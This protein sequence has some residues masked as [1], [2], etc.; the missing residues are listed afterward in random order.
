MLLGVIHEKL[1]VQLRFPLKQAICK[2]EG[3]RGQGH[4][5][6]VRGSKSNGAA[7]LLHASQCG[8]AAHRY[9]RKLLLA[10]LQAAIQGFTAAKCFIWH[11]L[12]QAPSQVF[13]LAL[14]P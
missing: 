1:L 7:C 2:R 14:V 8:N 10:P 13:S 4:G 9:V 6:G 3:I 11:M 5:N 12:G